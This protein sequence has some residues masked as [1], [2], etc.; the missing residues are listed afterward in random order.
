[1]TLSYYGSFDYFHQVFSSF[2]LTVKNGVIDEYCYALHFS[3]RAG[4]GMTSSFDAECI[5]CFS[6]IG[7]SDTSL[8]TLPVYPEDLL[9]E[10]PALEKA[11]NSNKNNYTYKERMSVTDDQGNLVQRD[12]IE[13]VDEDSLRTYGYSQYYGHLVDDYIYPV[14]K[15]SYTS[16]SGYTKTYYNTTLTYKDDGVDYGSY[17]MDVS[18]PDWGGRLS[19]LSSCHGYGLKIFKKAEN[20]SY[21]PEEGKPGR[22]NPS[23]ESYLDIAVKTFGHDIIGNYVSE[24]TGESWNYHYDSISIFLDDL[25]NVAHV[26]YGYSYTYVDKEGVSHDYVVSAS[27]SFSDI[28]S[29]KIEVPTDP[30]EDIVLDERLTVAKESIDVDNY[31]LDDR[32]SATGKDGNPIS[33]AL[34]GTNVNET[35]YH[36]ERM[37]KY[38]YI[39]ASANY[40][41]D[42]DE[43][44]SPI[45]R[46]LNAD[47][48]SYY[49]DDAYYAC[50]HFTNGEYE[51]VS[52][53]AVGTYTKLTPLSQLDSY[54]RFFTYK[55]TNSTTGV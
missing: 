22:Y 20:D 47:F 45:Y 50:R 23:E 5:G 11:V 30:D 32:Y 25:G 41:A 39:N 3:P 19:Y 55:S 8:P 26:D 31:S 54:L 37:G 6:N 9:K 49:G 21:I 36:E 48:Y 44:E 29:T 17:D 40:I 46:W 18:S 33:L 51:D 35:I 34:D 24:A 28:G 10:E 42:Y 38:E 4:K 16:S 12:Y 7:V 52:Q 53:K 43:N 1:M 27:G 13:E 2:Y 14:V 15:E